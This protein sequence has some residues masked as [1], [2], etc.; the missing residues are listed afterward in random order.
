M[1]RPEEG[2]HSST[3][4][5]SSSSQIT[6]DK[7]VQVPSTHAAVSVHRLSSSQSP[8]LSDCKQ[9]SSPPHLQ[10][11]HGSSGG[12]SR[13]VPIQPF[14]PHWSESVQG[15]L[16]SHGVSIGRLVRIQRPLVWSHVE[17]IQGE[18]PPPKQSSSVAHCTPGSGCSAVRLVGMLSVGSHSL[19]SSSDT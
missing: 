7:G 17:T 9:P 1:H 5:D 18:E 15:S 11:A 16:S 10:K 14:G 6:D 13:G 2:A 3:V 19:V 4:Q 8:S 12:Q